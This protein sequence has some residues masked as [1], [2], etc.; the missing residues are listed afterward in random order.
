MSWL[1]VSISEYRAR[2][3]TRTR[4]WELSMLSEIIKV[5]S[6]PKF[7]F[8]KKG[9]YSF[10]VGNSRHVANQ[11][12]PPRLASLRESTQSLP[13]ATLFKNRRRCDFLVLVDSHRCLLVLIDDRSIRASARPIHREL[14]I[15]RKFHCTG[16]EEMLRPLRYAILPA[17][18]LLTFLITTSDRANAQVVTLAPAATPVV[19]YVPERRGLFGLRT[20]YRPTVS[21]MPTVSAVQ[22]VNY[23][24][25]TA[26]YA[27]ATTAYYAPAPA[28]TAYYAPA[29]TTTYYAPTA[30]TTAYYAPTTT[31]YAPA[32]VASVPVVSAPT[33]TSYYAP[34]P[35][36]TYY[37]PILP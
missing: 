12:K 27:P 15:D 35:V 19:T 22:T 36:T 3:T 8:G 26:Y 25:T 16:D 18:V 28:T 29:P 17:F 31:Y 7:S 13:F 2:R 10:K 20:V 32:P 5:E 33:T 24:P 34:A 6:P 9:C 4:F 23:A 37:A 1:T 14:I 21:Y 11:V 30:S